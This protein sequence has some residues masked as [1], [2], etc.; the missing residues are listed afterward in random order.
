M[1]SI[2]ETSAAE[3]RPGTKAAKN[4]PGTTSD[5]LTAFEAQAAKLLPAEPTP[6]ANVAAAYTLGWA[7][8]DALT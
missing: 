5:A 8:G 1:V 7:V 6:D 4:G 2:S 3:N